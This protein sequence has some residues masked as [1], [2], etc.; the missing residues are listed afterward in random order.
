MLGFRRW[1]APA[2]VVATLSLPAAQAQ[3]E[4][5]DT[6]AALGGGSGIVLGSST[7]CSLTTIGHDA[8]G[9]LVG[10]TAG[11]CGEAGTPVHGERF[12]DAGVIGVVRTSDAELDYAVIEFDPT[13]VTPLR[14][15]GATTIT[16]VGELPAAWDVAC[17]N[18][19]TS[20]FACGTVWS[21]G[22]GGF[23]DQA[24][25]GYGD[26]GGPLT[27]GDQL[28]G[29]VSRPLINDTVGLRFSCTSPMNPLH[30]PVVAVSF[31]AVRAA[32]DATDDIGSGFQPI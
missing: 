3:A 26:S 24:C 2:V 20:G 4:P 21:A 11:H 6:R 18:G 7:K 5:G 25:S 9:R 27:I 29:L 32:V 14:T 22:P 12:P 8:A 17:Q 15:V 28:V 13:A 19:R 16:G 1:V 31:D 30:S 23:L 10:F